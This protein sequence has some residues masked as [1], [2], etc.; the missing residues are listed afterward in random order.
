VRLNSFRTGLLAF[1]GLLAVTTP[2]FSQTPQSGIEKQKNLRRH[3]IQERVRRNVGKAL[4]DEDA[5]RRLFTMGDEAVP[6]LIKFLS[7]ADKE[8]RAGAARGLAY[9]ENQHGMQALRTLLHP[10]RMRKQRP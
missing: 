9:I 7:D 5:I 8:K 10:R 1:T 6:S 2:A 3:S 4:E